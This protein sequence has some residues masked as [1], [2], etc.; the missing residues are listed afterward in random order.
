MNNENW[1][2]GNWEAF[3]YAIGCGEDLIATVDF[4]L[5]EGMANAHLIAAAPELYKELKYAE[6]ILREVAKVSGLTHIDVESCTNMATKALA[7]A[8]GEL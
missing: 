3:F 6:E 5:D 8:R 4:K 7:K 1:T 2:K